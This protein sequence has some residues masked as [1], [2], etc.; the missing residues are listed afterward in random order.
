MSYGPFPP[1]VLK[2]ISEY[3]GNQKCCDCPSLDTD[4]GSVNHGTLICLEC[5]GRHRS[6]GVHVS[7]V[8][9]VYMDTWTPVQVSFCSCRLPLWTMT[10]SASQLELHSLCPWFCCFCLDWNDATRREWANQGFLQKASD[11][12]LSH[13]NSLQH[14]GCE[15]L[16]RQIERES[17]KGM[18]LQI[19]YMTYSSAISH[20]TEIYSRPL[21][22]FL[23]LISQF[24]YKLVV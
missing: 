14:K 7:F 13:H 3:P 1:S 18:L 21:I 15:S 8:R 6:L 16:S 2:E 22:A 9:S 11:R 5:A 20:I 10:I 12:E 4:W 17:W 24:M 19:L 23:N